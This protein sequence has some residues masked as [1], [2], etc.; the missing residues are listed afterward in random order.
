MGIMAFTPMGNTVTFTA[1]TS[2]PTPVQATSSI[3]GATQYKIVIPAGNNTVFIG[4]GT[5]SAAATAGAANVTSSG[6]AF[7]MLAGTDQVITLNGNMYFTGVTNT[8]TAQVY[9]MPGDG[10]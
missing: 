6:N 5:T 3:I 4:F 10:V 2:A 9:I 1:A 7:V 8:G